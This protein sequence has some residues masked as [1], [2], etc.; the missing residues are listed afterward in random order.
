MSSQVNNQTQEPVKPQGN[1]SETMFS[2]LM[3]TPGLESLLVHPAFRKYQEYL[4]KLR[5]FYAALLV[6]QSPTERFDCEIKGKI[7]ELDELINLPEVIK[8]RFKTKKSEVV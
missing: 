3:G 2:E 1:L 7:K 4:S 5:G 6:Y 8:E